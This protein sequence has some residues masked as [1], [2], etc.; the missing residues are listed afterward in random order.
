MNKWDGKPT[1]TLETQTQELQG[2][3]ITN[4]GSFRKVGAAPVY[5]RQFPRQRGKD[6]FTP[7]PMERNSN[8]FLQDLS[9]G[10]YDEY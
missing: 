5:R 3:P 7:D 2:K 1:S 4:G 8:P 6:D 10:S 9:E